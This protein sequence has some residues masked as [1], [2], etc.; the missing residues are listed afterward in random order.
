MNYLFEKTLLSQLFYIQNHYFF[1]HYV[2]KLLSL[3]IPYFFVEGHSKTFSICSYV[4]VQPRKTHLDMT[5]Q[6]L[7]EL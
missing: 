2:S 6:L 1:V 5:E 7:T 3:L 4:L